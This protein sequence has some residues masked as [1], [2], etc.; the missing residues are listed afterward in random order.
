MAPQLDFGPLNTGLDG[1]LNEKIFTVSFTQVLKLLLW[2]LSCCN[3][4][5]DVALPKTLCVLLCDFNGGLFA[6]LISYF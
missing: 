6:A 2:E 5:H 1:E 4:L 3:D